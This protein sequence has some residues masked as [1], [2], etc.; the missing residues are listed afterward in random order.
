MF[1]YMFTMS[2]KTAGVKPG[3]VSWPLSGQG[4]WQLDCCA[5]TQLGLKSDTLNSV[6]S[7]H[8]HRRVAHGTAWEGRC[9]VELDHMGLTANYLVIKGTL[10]VAS[11]PDYRCSVLGWLA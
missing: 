2:D 10:V 5:P 4:G 11:L 3:S 8:V 7:E 6:H 9:E 1:I